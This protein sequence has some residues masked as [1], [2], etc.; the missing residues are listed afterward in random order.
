MKNN[1]DYTQWKQWKW[2]SNTRYYSLVFDQDLFGKWTVT[3]IWGGKFTKI[4]RYKKNYCSINEI[5][6]LAAQVHKR[7]L[8]RG[9][10]LV[11]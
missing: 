8:S 3:K 6:N 5:E 10:T 4:H 9:Y 11:N 2:Y 7:R 1:F